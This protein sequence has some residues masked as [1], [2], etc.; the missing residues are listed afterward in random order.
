MLWTTQPPC[1]SSCLRAATVCLPAGQSIKFEFNRWQI[2]LKAFTFKRVVEIDRSNEL[3]RVREVH[4]WTPFGSVFDTQKECQVGDR[5]ASGEPGPG[6]ELQPQGPCL[7]HQALLGAV[8]HK[9]G[10]QLSPSVP[11]RLKTRQ[12]SSDAFCI[13]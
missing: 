10:Q 11:R 3:A 12:A 8:K 13:C 4:S 2:G 6:R 9:E 1:V 5:P 7:L